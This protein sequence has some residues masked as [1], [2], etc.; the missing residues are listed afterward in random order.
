[1]TLR[2][3][4]ITGASY[5]FGLVYGSQQEHITVQS[6]AYRKYIATRTNLFTPRTAGAACSGK[7]AENNRTLVCTYTLKLSISWKFLEKIN[8]LHTTM[9]SQLRWPSR[10]MSLLLVF[11]PG[12][13][14]PSLLPLVFAPG[15]RLRP[16][17]LPSVATPVSLC[18]R[19][20][21]SPLV[22]APCL[23]LRPCM[24]FALRR[25]SP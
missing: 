13:C 1:M 12:L 16:W 15:L 20:S 19:S 22:F 21:S 4:C 6:P 10:A 14:P 23:R 3:S 17:S 9:E 2:V 5:I 25:Y 18:P 7:Y 24:V 8:M 11:A